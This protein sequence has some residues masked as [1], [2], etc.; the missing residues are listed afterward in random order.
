MAEHDEYEEA[1][2]LFEKA[3]KLAPTNANIYVHKA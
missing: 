2:R 1:K 3:S